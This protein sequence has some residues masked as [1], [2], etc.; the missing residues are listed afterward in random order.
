MPTDCSR[1]AALC[2]LA[3][4]FDRSPAFAFDKPAGVPCPELD[5][6][7]CRIHAERTE[8]G[9]A[10]CVGYDCGGAGARVTGEVFRGRSWR[11]EPALRLPMIEAFRLGRDAQALEELLDAARAL[12]LDAEQ[13]ARR[14]ELAARA[15]GA[16]TEAHLETTTTGLAVEVRSFVRALRGVGG[17]R[18]GSDQRSP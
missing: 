14:S 8:R 16:W 11:T 6:H 15:S 3:L 10:G 13:E 1:C 5:G 4:A 17:A 7:R 12:P 2:C 9:F 18:R